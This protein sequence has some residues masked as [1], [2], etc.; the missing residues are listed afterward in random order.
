MA[1][2]RGVAGI[3]FLMVCMVAGCQHSTEQ[4]PLYDRLGGDSKISAIVDDFVDRAMADPKVNFTRKGT[5]SEW[6]PTPDNLDKLKSHLKEFFEAASGGQ[7][8]YEGRDMRSVHA[9]MGITNDEFDAIEVDLAK[10]LAKYDV[11][12][13]ETSELLAVV[14][15]T[16]TQIVEPK[17]N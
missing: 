8:E 12:A 16:R 3:G 10:T 5:A 7:R 4:L 1:Q 15:S 13:K 14:E 17:L 9:G 11:G 6:D 2:F